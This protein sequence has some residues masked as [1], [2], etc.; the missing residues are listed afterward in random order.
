MINA[1]N[2]IEGAALIAAV[3]AAALLA[4]AISQERT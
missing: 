4:K 1:S 2:H 3:Y